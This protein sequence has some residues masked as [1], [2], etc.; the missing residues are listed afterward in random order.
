MEAPLLNAACRR[1]GLGKPRARTAATRI[2]PRP[3]FL[4]A[5]RRAT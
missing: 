3:E 1:G 2:T 4:S 5:Q